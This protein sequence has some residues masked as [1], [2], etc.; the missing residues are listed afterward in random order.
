M[1]CECGLSFV[2]GLESDEQIHAE[3]HEEYLLG[4]RLEALRFV[5]VRPHREGY[6]L[7]VIDSTVPENIRHSLA[8]AA[9]VSRFETPEFPAGYDGSVTDAQEKMFIV[10]KEDRA[11]AVA[12]TGLDEPHWR[13]GWTALGGV[14]LVERTPLIGSRQKIGRI[15]V[16][17][18][19]RGSG[20]AAAL[21][22]EISSSLSV[23]LAELG[24]ELPLTQSGRSLLHRL[25]PGEWLGRG[26]P[27][28][29]RDTLSSEDGGQ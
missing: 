2:E 17:K 23:P 29:L 9:M 1:K 27:F 26:D 3:M 13:L 4:P 8:R 22:T 20:I 25:V 18:S 21:A 14:Y 28:A 19:Y 6:G 7:A 10:A 24:W 12:L 16:A 5:S 11:I 15:W